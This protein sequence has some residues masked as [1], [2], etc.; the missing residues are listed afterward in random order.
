MEEL[1]PDVIRLEK[2]LRY[3][4]EQLLKL[5]DK[6]DTLNGNI[7]EIAEGERNK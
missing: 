3:W 1:L 4:D 6:Y 5:I 2:K 7:S